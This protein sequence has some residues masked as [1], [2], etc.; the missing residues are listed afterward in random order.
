MDTITQVLPPAP[1]LAR[2]ETVILSG[3]SL[4]LPS[5]DLRQH[6]ACATCGDLLCDLH[7]HMR[8]EPSMQCLRCLS[9]TC[10]GNCAGHARLAWL[11]QELTR[12]GAPAPAP[13]LNL[14]TFTWCR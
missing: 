5:V 7:L 9:T 10:D 6:L 2:Q 1:D 4:D 8:A 14:D 12:L 3:V 11:E 13:A